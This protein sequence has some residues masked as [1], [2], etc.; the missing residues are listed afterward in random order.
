LK[1]RKE[2]EFLSIKQNE[3]V[4]STEK[5]KLKNIAKCGKAIRKLKTGKD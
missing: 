5:A 3:M 2:V 4:R 1:L